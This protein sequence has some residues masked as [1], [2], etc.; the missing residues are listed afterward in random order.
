MRLAAVLL[1]ASAC[2][3]PGGAHS[4]DA[5]PDVAV[6][7]APTLPTLTWMTSQKIEQVIGDVDWSSCTPTTM[8]SC[9]ATASKTVTA[10]NVLGNGLGYSFEYQGALIFL[11]GDTI[12][13]GTW[14]GTTVGDTTLN[15]HGKDPFASSSSTDPQ[16]PLEL[17][18]FKDPANATLPLFITPTDSGGNRLP[19]AG[20]DIPNSGIAVGNDL[21][22]VY[23]TG[24]TTTCT[25]PCDPHAGDYSV[26]VKYDPQNTAAPFPVQRPISTLTNS[27]GGHFIID[28]LHAGT[29]GDATIYTFGIG[30]PKNSLSLPDA[31]AN[32][33]LAS[34]PES[35]FVAG[36]QTRYLLG[37]DSSNAPMWSAPGAAE[38][39]TLY[40][41]VVDNPNGDMP[42]P[43]PSASNVSVSYANDLK[44]WLMTY[45][46]GKY[47]SAGYSTDGIY[48]TYAANPWGPW[49]KPQLIYNACRDG[50][51]GA[52]IHYNASTICPGVVAGSGPVGPMIGSNDPTA[53]RGGAFAPQMIERFTRYSAG[54]LTIDYTM[55]TWNPYTV[56]RMRSAFRVQ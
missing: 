28:A 35:A 5:P 13:T 10:A 54:V 33:Y 4:P 14:D 1:A 25:S 43:P 19:F 49:A 51:F 44:L 24:S 3:H 29:D 23:S 37:L 53:E 52:F 30:D 36:G 42:A 21:E 34:D 7:A 17:T 50:G 31:P 32:I 18:F 6:D 2:G 20:D 16:L 11:F 40:P 39:A 22:I 48:F 12:P 56:V 27:Y 45:D 41:I 55:S 38:P 26:L 9:T 15:F 46:G 47:T 8:A